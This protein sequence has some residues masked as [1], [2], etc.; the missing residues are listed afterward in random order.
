MEE[1]QEEKGYSRWEWFFYMLLIPALFASLLGAILLSLLGHD[2]IGK[3]KE[4]GN[5]VPYLEKIVPGPSNLAETSEQ[6]VATVESLQMQLAENDEQFS[7]LE[8]ELRE[9]E[10]TLAA[11]NQQIDEL[12]Q[13]LEAKQQGDEERDKQYQELAKIYTTMSARNAASIIENLSLEESVSVM[14]RMKTDQSANI[15]AK[16]D[17]KKAADISILLKE[18]TISKDDDIA[19]LQQRIQ[20]LTKAV[21]E[22]R[23]QDAQSSL[24]SLVASFAR[25]Q[26]REAA[27][28]LASLLTTNQTQAVSIMAKMEEAQR[29]QVLAAMVQI[30][31]KDEAAKFTSELLR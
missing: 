7:M 14:S 17:P 25:M 9:K 28:I 29:A 4:W 22:T 3:A 31:K 21:S 16:M 5:S 10:A 18:G 12:K 23:P 30:N 1:V 26:P 2:V 15:L 13:Q 8:Q 24:D 11:L 19:A 27:T 20:A 6:E